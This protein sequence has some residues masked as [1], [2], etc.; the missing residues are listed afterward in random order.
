MAELGPL[1]SEI[2]DI[3]WRLKRADVR[4]VL[5]ELNKKRSS[6]L[7]YTTVMTVMTH[8]F[9]K[10]LLRRRKVSRGYLYKPVIDRGKYV[11]ETISDFI[12]G[13]IARYKE[14]VASNILDALEDASPEQVSSLV[15]ELKKR[16]YIIK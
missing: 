9:Q 6:K 12:A 13:I 14:P 3:I 4:T 11:M 16:G 8:L 10:G 7:A 15:Q 5:E 2:M 1:Q